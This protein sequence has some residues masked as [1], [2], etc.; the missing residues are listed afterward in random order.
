MDLTIAE[1]VMLCE[2][3]GEKLRKLMKEDEDM[4]SYSIQKDFLRYYQDQIQE[5]QTFLEQIIHHI[6]SMQKNTTS[7]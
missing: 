1:K 6:R 3:Y 4:I 5:E 7:V 2:E